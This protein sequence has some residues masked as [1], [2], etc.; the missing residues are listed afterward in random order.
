MT[1]IPAIDL[2]DGRLVRLRHGNYDAVT[3]YGLDA[4]E[5]ARALYELGARRIHLVDLNA[6]RAKPGSGEEA[7]TNRKLIGDIRRAVPAQLELGGGIRTREDVRE[8]LD[9]GVQRLVLGTLFARQPELA[10]EWTAA[11]GPV[12]LAGIDAK[13][14]QVKIAGWEAGGGV[15]DLELASRAKD[16]GVLGIIYTNIGRDGTLEGPDI[17]RTCEI[18]RVSG[19]PVI[20]SGG[21]GS[22]EDVRAVAAAAEKFNTEGEGSLVGLITGKAYY[23]GKI[24]LERLLALYPQIPGGW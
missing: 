23:E 9:L 21:I 3:D 8:L 2:L 14:G 7:R 5:A 10:A 11:F 20:L 18:A 12:F 6:A 24:D 17:E 22:N 15:S 1:I 13:D 4:V 16:Y 19:L